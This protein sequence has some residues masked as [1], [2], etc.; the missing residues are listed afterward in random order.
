MAHWYVI[1]F[2]YWRL[3]R[4][5]VQIPAMESDFWSR[6][7][8]WI[9]FNTWSWVIKGNKMWDWG[10][11][12]ELSYQPKLFKMDWE[13]LVTRLAAPMG[14]GWQM[15]TIVQKVVNSKY[16]ILS[17]GAKSPFAKSPL[18]KSFV[19]IAPFLELISTLAKTYTT[20]AREPSIYLCNLS[21]DSA[22]G[23]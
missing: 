21:I 20:T 5:W 23:G 11:V 22:S 12:I 15:T 19:L 14:V 18:A 1:C 7:W 6:I 16:V 13:W 4:T 2:M 17:S 3:W 9:N 8:M 10:L